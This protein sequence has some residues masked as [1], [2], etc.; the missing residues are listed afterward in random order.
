MY[1]ELYGDSDHGIPEPS[2][3][4]IGKLAGGGIM[5]D[6][7]NGA[8]LQKSLLN[9]EVEKASGDGQ[10]AH[11]DDCHHHLRNIWFGAAMKSLS[12]Y[13]SDFLRDHLDEISP[14]LRVVCSMEAIIRTTHKGFSLT[15]NYPKGCG[16][17]FK[18]YHDEYHP[19]TLLFHVERVSG[20]RQDIAVEGACAVYWN[21]PYYV[22]FLDEQLRMIGN[23]G[24]ILQE[25]LFVI[26]TSLPMIALFRISSILHVAICI[27]MRWLA[28]N[29]HKMKDHNWSVRSMGRALDILES[30]LEKIL[31]DQ[32][33][34]LDR[35]F[36]MGIFDE[37]RSELLPFDDF[38]KYKFEQ[39]ATRL[40]GGL[41]TK[42]VPFAM[43]C[44]ELFAPTREE[45]IDSNAIS[46]ELGGIVG[47]ALLKELHDPTKA[48]FKYLSSLGS[49]HSLMHRKPGVHEALL[50][51]MAVNDPSERS[52]GAGT[53]ELQV[54]GRID[55]ASAF[56]MGQAK[57]NGNM[58]RK[59]NSKRKRKEETSFDG[60]I[61][62]I[63][64]KLQTSLLI[65][66]M[67]DAPET[68]RSNS[69]ALGKQR[70][71]RRMK[72]KLLKDA[73]LKRASED[74]IESYYYFKMSQ[75]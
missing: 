17:K 74:H 12:K 3:M 7:C 5:S 44:D 14:F 47:Q 72:E 18:P 9:D 73:K 42:A 1:E 70:E 30:A 49:S 52:F 75:S 23:E 65:T 11:V 35:Q 60:L 48:T 64:Q 71:A 46:I 40:L 54:F 37:L 19:G 62:Q 66:A 67:R 39:Q 24:N 31:L 26:F 38:L 2:E 56:S 29:T 15:N 69:D 10:R 16:E 22:E 43:L 55:L 68:K 63:N 57:V 58:C 8:Q 34:I 25:N 51:V 20:S 6:T 27:P 61:H 13:L 32:S 36:M 28:G 59:L 50:G 45:N 41:Q 53:W 33:L 4:D 21:R